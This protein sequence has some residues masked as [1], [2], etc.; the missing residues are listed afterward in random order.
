MRSLFF[1]SALLYLVSAANGLT[2]QFDENICYHA[3]VFSGCQNYSVRFESV[4]LYLTCSD[5]HAFDETTAKCTDPSEFQC[6]KTETTIQSSIDLNLPSTRFSKRFLPRSVFDIIDP[7]VKPVAKTVFK[8]A[9]S[10]MARDDPFLRDYI[11][12]IVYDMVDDDETSS[13]MKDIF[14]TAKSIYGPFAVL[15]INP[16]YRSQIPQEQLDEAKFQFYNQTRENFGK[17]FEKHLPM[18]LRKTGDHMPLILEA[19]ER[20]EEYSGDMV[21]ELKRDLVAFFANHAE[22]LLTIDES[23]ANVEN[24]A[25]MKRDLEPVKIALLKISMDYLS[26]SPNSW[27]N[28]LFSRNSVLYNLL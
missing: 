26:H 23:Y 25:R 3:N 12:P 10:A 8:M 24:V 9:T 5:G 19:V 21:H 27:L 20:M 13:Q 2:C 22:F 1:A 28:F 4:K 18:I 6:D 17:I 14:W 16:H 15:T 11:L 7:F